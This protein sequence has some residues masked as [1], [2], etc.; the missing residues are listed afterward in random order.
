MSVRTFAIAFLTACCAASAQ[1]PGRIP[2]IGLIANSIPAAELASGTTTNPGPKAI[3]ESLRELGWVDGRNI[4]L[5]WK[6]AEGK[7]DRWPAHVDE[8]LRIPVDVL[9]V[10]H[11]GT[12][13]IALQKSR[14]IPIV[15]PTG[16]GLLTEKLVASFAR[17]GGNLTGMSMEAMGELDAKRLAACS[18]ARHRRLRA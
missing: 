3:E 6:T 4:Q 9:V 15:F 2:R 14:T 8:M 10:F 5:F 13:K 17:P 7:Y 11:P 12:A 1:A 16:T 18:K